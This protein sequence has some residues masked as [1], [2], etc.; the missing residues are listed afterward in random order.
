MKKTA[1][2]IRMSIIDALTYRED[3]FLY[4]LVG[5]VHPLVILSVWLFIARSGA[6]TPLTAAEFVQYYLLVLVIKLITSAWSDVFISSDIRTGKISSFLT[7][8]APFFI[9]S[10]GN[11][12]GEKIVKSIFL[13]PIVV[14]CLI[15]F[16]AQPPHIDLGGF[17]L[18]AIST[19]AAAGVSFLIDICVGISAFW[20]EDARSV[21]DAVGVMSYSLSGALIPIVALPAVV[22]QVNEYLPFRYTLSLPIEI[23]MGNLTSL[24][25]IQALCIQFSWL[26][27][28]LFIFRAMWSSGTKR[29]SAVG[30]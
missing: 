7:K 8:P 23:L 12:V 21:H 6:Q 14:I 24:Q 16:R 29:Y 11:N 10:L 3:V 22:R 4:T 17:M 27:A 18:F 1:A 13:V 9:F 5:I 30:A 26:I 25:I 15:F 19:I 28:L 2:L 20:L